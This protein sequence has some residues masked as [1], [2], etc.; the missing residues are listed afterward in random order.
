VNNEGTACSE[1][2]ARNQDGVIGE[3]EL[4][5]RLRSAKRVFLLEPQY[6]RKYLPLGL[7]KIATFVKQNGGRVWFGRKYLGPPVDL[8]CATSLFTYDS[9]KVLASLRSAGSVAKDTPIIA[10]GIY[11]SLMWRHLLSE[12]GDRVLVFRGFSKVLDELV[13]DYSLRWGM[14]KPWPSF[15]FTFTSRGCPNRCAYCAVWRIEQEP[16]INPRWRDHILLEKPCAMISDNNLSAAPPEHLYAVLDFLEKTQRKVVFDNGFDVKHITDEMAARLARLRFV[17]T[18]M[19]TAFDRI[20]EDGTFQ[21]AIER[22]IAAGVKASD[23]MVYSLFNYRDKP[24]EAM[25]R[26]SQIHRLGAKPYPT[27]Y[28]PLNQSAPRRE[29]HHVG[30]HWTWPLVRAFRAYWLFAGVYSKH[31]FEE[32]ARGQDKIELSEEDWAAWHA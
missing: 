1:A 29:E 6:G 2:Q 24:R 4:L 15:S 19:R 22:L 21:I 26:L 28:T 7:A 8:I 31:D 17:R 11:A 12:M 25:Y 9:A 32:W 14:E 10:G 3:A 23:I 5:D 18:G 27:M 30:K 16:W 20:E 13:P